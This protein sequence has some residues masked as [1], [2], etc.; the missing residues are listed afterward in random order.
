[1]IDLKANPFFLNDEDIAWINSTIAEMTDEEKIGQL[2][3]PHGDLNKEVVKREMLDKKVAGIMFRPS[4]GAELLEMNRYVQ[5]ESKI[6]MLIAANLEAGGNGT[7][8]DGTFFGKQ[9]QVAAT[10]DFE[11]AYR[12]GVICG[13]EAKSVGCNWAFAPIIDI[14][15][16]YRNPITNVRTFGSDPDKV[17]GCGKGYLKGAHEEGIAV[18]I[19][20]F[21]GDGRDERDQHL[22]TSINDF[23]C[24]EWDA[25]YGRI[26]KELIDDGALTVMVGHIAQPAYQKKLN[27]G[28]HDEEVIP[29]TLSPELLNGL[30]REKLGF[31]G[32][33]VTDASEMMGFTTAMARKEAVPYSIAAGCDMFLFNKDINE[34]YAYMMD[35]YKNGVITEE[36]M[37]EALTRILAAKAALGLHTAK[38][39]G[40]LVPQPEALK[41][42]N[43]AQF[44]AWAKECADKA[45]T[46]VKDTQ[47]L[48][49]ISPEK[50]KN[51]FMSV[52]GAGADLEKIKVRMPELFRKEGFN[53]T[54]FDP[55]EEKKMVKD[56]VEVF[57]QKY[58]LAV[59]IADVE[60]YSNQTTARISWTPLHG[61]NGRPWYTKEV[62]TMMISVANPYVLIDA[63]MIK[64]FVNAYSTSDYATDA[65]MEK[66]MGRSEF[67]GVNPVDPFC[68]DRY[69]LKL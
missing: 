12:L 30:L 19:K 28:F 43:N 67:K 51:V 23:S 41:E 13:R 21:P 33:I 46:L 32:M 47:S 20:H 66:I 34:D 53:V 45:V 5:S 50:H 29:A 7:T 9:M 57:K 24:E 54:V 27:P 2:F 61:S 10:N 56:G 6:P 22:V 52:F 18:S 11:Q 59:V 31:N 37:T 55:E 58:D 40:T 62:P 26:Y 63:P 25:T 42:L 8:T 38:K 1:M 14:D 65:V 48:L 3:C 68:G 4:P 35:G 36:R 16:N 49:P 60:T 39:N 17:L 69:D 15:Y 44:D 64:T